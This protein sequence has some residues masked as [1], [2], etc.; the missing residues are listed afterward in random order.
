MIGTRHLSPRVR[1]E[2]DS[3]WEQEFC[4]RVNCAYECSSFKLVTDYNNSLI[5]EFRKRYPKGA[6][7]RGQY[8]RPY[9]IFYLTVRPLLKTLQLARTKDDLYVSMFLLLKFMGL[10]DTDAW[11]KHPDFSRPVIEKARGWPAKISDDTEHPDR[12]RLQKFLGKFETRLA[13]LQT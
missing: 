3:A 6:P 11:V 9:E 8:P 4:E 13:N 1:F 5:A 12:V 7:D 2:M 10:A